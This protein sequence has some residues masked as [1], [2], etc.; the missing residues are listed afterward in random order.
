MVAMCG[1]ETGKR[2]VLYDISDIEIKNRR[3]NLGLHLPICN[4][5]DGDLLEH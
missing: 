4:K 2:L 1:Y 5:K 3:L